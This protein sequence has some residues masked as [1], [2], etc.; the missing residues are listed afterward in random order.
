MGA[1]HKA[2][3]NI[4]TLDGW[5][6]VAVIAVVASHGISLTSPLR[7]L[8]PFGPHGVYI[9]FVISGFLIA[10]KL[11]EEE[12]KHG[13]P[14]L[15]AFYLRRLFRITPPAVVYLSVVV[16]LGLV[17]LLRPM[18]WLQWASC[19]FFFQ[20]YLGE[21]P[22]RLP[23]TGHFWS[24]AVE[25]HFYLVLPLMLL[26]LGSVRLRRVVP[27]LC[28]AAIGWRWF[29]DHTGFMQQ[30][31]PGSHDAHRTDRC[32][33]YLLWGVFLAFL[34][35]RASVRVAL[36]KYLSTPVWIGLAGVYVICVYRPPPFIGVT[37]EALVIAALLSGTVL[38]PDGLPGRM[39]EHPWMQ[40]IGRISYS[41]YL[42]Q[43]LF[44]VASFREPELLQRFPLNVVCTLACAIASYYWIE[45]P[46]I[47][48]GRR[49][50]AAR[51]LRQQEKQEESMN[52][53]L[54]PIS[55]GTYV[56]RRARAW[57]S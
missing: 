4:P 40:F 28:L 44:F 56:T 17:G 34:F 55:V 7:Y 19:T 21:F 43:Q 5:R 13:R 2:E 38:R 22:G 20:N 39:M 45:Q 51:A 37:V 36:K 11:L 35:R 26:L 52:P 1:G 12:A 46:L 27:L 9:F 49:V 16:L 47:A 48:V 8:R 23:Y 14:D 41:I 24:L 10:S 50:L 6:A 32:F 3:R 25:E 57:F 54:W 42:W 31:F 33:D 15:G 53:L 18:S 30:L 29:D